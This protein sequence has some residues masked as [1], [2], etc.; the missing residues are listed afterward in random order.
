MITATLKIKNGPIIT[1]D[2]AKTDLRRLHG[3]CRR[4]LGQPIGKKM[5]GPRLYW[6]FEKGHV[7]LDG[8]VDITHGY[9][10]VR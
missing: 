8:D 5:K 2:Y 10:G 7:Y 4:I 1:K 9:R 3:A 6:L